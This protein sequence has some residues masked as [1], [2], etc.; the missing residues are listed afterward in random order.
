MGLIIFDFLFDTV[1]RDLRRGEN[2]ISLVGCSLQESFKKTAI[3][4][5]GIQNNLEA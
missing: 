4:Y 3:K 2:E 5:Q 1:K